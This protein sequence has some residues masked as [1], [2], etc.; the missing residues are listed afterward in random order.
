[1]RTKLNHL[2]LHCKTTDEEFKAEFFLLNKLHQ[3]GVT[4]QWPCRVIHKKLALAFFY[5]EQPNFSGWEHNE[6]VKK[7]LPHKQEGKT[8]LNVLILETSNH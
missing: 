5:Q 8:S 7:Y 6:Q 3:K 1:M 2:W 4:P